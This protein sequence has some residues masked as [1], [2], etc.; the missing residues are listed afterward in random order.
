MLSFAF[1]SSPSGSSGCFGCC[2]G[3]LCGLCLLAQVRVCESVSGVLGERRYGACSMP[4]DATCSCGL[5]G[6]A[7]PCDR[8]MVNYELGLPK[9][10]REDLF[11]GR[12]QI[13]CRRLIS[14][15]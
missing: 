5:S 3:R 7:M 8:K 6:G 1:L 14:V 2:T 10:K 12:D 9:G 4:R 11:R 13:L 15:E